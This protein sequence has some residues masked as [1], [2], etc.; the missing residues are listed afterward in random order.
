MLGFFSMLRIRIGDGSGCDIG[1][2]A[3]VCGNLRQYDPADMVG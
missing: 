1:C 3:R 2:F